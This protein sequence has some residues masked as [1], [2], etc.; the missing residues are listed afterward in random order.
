MRRMLLVATSFAL[1][2]ASVALAAS[3]KTGQYSAGS[4]SKDGINLRIKRHSFSVQRVSFQETCTSAS[5]SF[6][7]RFTFVSGSQAK[8]SGK[9]NSKGHLSGRYSSSA[10]TVNVTGKVKGSKAT[11]N[12]TESGDYTPQ[13]STKTY[14]CSGA[15]TFHA[16]RLVT[17]TSTGG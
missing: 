14:K 8:L 17:S 7:E 5:D 10:G 16:K 9:V 12:V 1:V 6:D 2:F 13:G 3:F 11:V 15:H 4:S